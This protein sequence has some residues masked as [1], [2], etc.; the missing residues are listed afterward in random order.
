[1]R[2]VFYRIGSER[3]DASWICLL[4]TYFAPLTNDAVQNLP[5]YCK[6]ARLESLQLWIYASVRLVDTKG[7]WSNKIRGY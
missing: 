6:Q 2:N 5:V 1:M 3:L 4:D 7:N